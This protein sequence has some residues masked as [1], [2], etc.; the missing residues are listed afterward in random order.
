MSIPASNE[1]IR[2]ALI[3]AG[4]WGRNVI[5]TCAALGGQVRLAAIA[6]GNPDT[7]ALAPPG[8]VVF[9]SWREMLAAGGLDGVIVCTPPDQ[10]AEMALAAIQSGIPVLVEKPLTRDV[11]EAEAVAGA[12]AKS[13]VPVMV[14]HI[15]LYNPAFRKLLDLLPTLGAVREIRGQA[16]NRGPYRADASVLWDWGPHDLAMI[17]TLL[18]TRPETLAARRLEQ[19]EIEG[20]R[21]ETLELALRYPGGVSASCI[22]GTLMDRRRILE[23]TCEGGTL[24]YDDNAPAKLTL[25]GV[26]VACDGPSPLATIISEFSE[27]AAR[28][29]TVDGGLG[30]G[31]EVV[32]LLARCETLLE[33]PCAA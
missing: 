11:A 10:H 20:V 31:V 16:G 33:G 24:V 28:R 21:A 7:A 26:P 17:G 18:G 23:V 15:H 29:R 6:S 3:G 19:A 32:R 2:L 14:D 25:D 13:G 27:V 8:C 22:I 30:L 4:R 12:A 1:P 9:A 5:K